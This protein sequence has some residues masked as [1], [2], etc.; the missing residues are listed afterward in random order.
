MAMTGGMIALG[1]NALV[2]TGAPFL[3]YFA[4]RHRLT[5]SVR[6]IAVGAVCFVLFALVIEQAFQVYVLRINPT[7]AAWFKAHKIAFAVYGALCAG[8]FEETA[9]LIGFSFLTRKRDGV[10]A[11][12]AYG[13]GHGG[14]EAIILGGLLSLVSLLLAILAHNGMLDSVLSSKLPAPALALLHNRLT[15]LTFW[16]ALPAGVERLS[17]LTFQIGLSFLVWRAVSLKA[18]LL[19]FLAILCHA[20]LDTPAALLQLGLLHMGLWPLEGTYAA[21]AV[22]VA[23]LLLIRLRM[24]GSERPGAN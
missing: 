16:H 12:L 21:L 13:I 18:W 15:Q 2:A 22:I 23:G 11:A 5:L 6:N 20:A 14:A 8:V 9:R 10:G 1:I 19:Y 17:A 7:S 4:F 3:I 24:V